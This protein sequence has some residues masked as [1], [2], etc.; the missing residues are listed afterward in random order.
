MGD[1]ERAAVAGTL[2]ATVELLP[3]A[4]G[5]KQP[6]I[7]VAFVGQPFFIA[8]GKR[9][10]WLAAAVHLL[11]GAAEMESIGQ[12]WLVVA[13]VNAGTIALDLVRHDDAEVEDAQRC[14]RA[15]VAATP[16]VGVTCA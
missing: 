11:A 15:V 16:L 2:R 10:R 8:Q 14:L 5:R 7:R 1:L 4:Y 12:G 9:H 13:D 3:T 6:T